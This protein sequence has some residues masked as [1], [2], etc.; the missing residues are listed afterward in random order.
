MVG[1]F[2]SMDRAAESLPPT[3]LLYT[4]FFEYPVSRVIQV[5]RQVR[6]KVPQARLLV[7]G[8]GMFGE[9]EVLLREARQAGLDKAVEYA[10][11]VE[12]ESLPAYFARAA[13]AIYPFDDT[14]VN[15]T[16]CPVK[17]LDL[18]ASGLPVVAEAV[19]EI[20]EVIRHRETG[21]LVQPGR[22]DEFAAAVVGL[23][24]D[25]SRRWSMGQAAARD[26]RARRSW[27][28]LAEMVETALA[29]AP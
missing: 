3:I 21:W 25:P 10:G 9:E 7:V 13:L 4:R 2:A 27:A 28:R 26:V 11:W 16:K 5:L 14:L 1:E 17:L 29:V 12:P 8:K 19:G 6:E 22:V 20:R 18:L 23:L 24:Q 15:R